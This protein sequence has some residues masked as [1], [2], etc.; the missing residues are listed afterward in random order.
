M[1]NWMKSLQEYDLEIVP[2]QIVRG[3]GLCKLVFDSVEKLESQIN[4]STINRH[5]EKQISCT[6][7]VP[8]SWYENIIFYLLYGTAPCN[9]DPKN[10]RALRLKS[11]SF[12]LINDTLFQNNFDGFFLRCLEKEESQK[13]FPGQN[14]IS[15]FNRSLTQDSMFVYNFGKLSFTLIPN[16]YN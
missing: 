7:T 11:A 12:Q 6:Q 16:P 9:I 4:T 8:N 1:E 15:G 3:E 13:G 2:A 10:R 5:D 14:V